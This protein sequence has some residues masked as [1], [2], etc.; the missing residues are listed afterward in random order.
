M[1]ITRR[2]FLKASGAAGAVLIAAPASGLG[3]SHALADV[4][5][6]GG[7]RGY[8]LDTPVFGG[9]LQYFRMPVSDIPARLGLCQEAAFSVIQTYVPWNVHEY[10]AGTLD[11]MGKTHPS[12]PNDHHLDPFDYGDSVGTGGLND[13]DLGLKVNTDLESFLRMCRDYGFSVILR[14][15]PFISDEWRNGG[16]PDWLLQTAPDDM[17]EYGPDGTP[18]L[19][20]PPFSS[21]PAV[22][23]LLGGM[24]LFYFPSP[25]YASPYYLSAVRS[26]LTGFAEFVR[27]WLRSNG[28]PVV[29]VQVDDE[30]CFYYHFGAF[31][32][33][34]N[35][36]MV[37]RYVAA[38]GE[39]PPRAWPL[40]VEGIASLRPAFK[41][42]KFKAQQIGT[43]LGTLAGDLRAAGVDVPITHEM[44]LSLTPPADFAA[45]A[46]AVL[47]QPELYPGA[48]GPEAMPLIELT[49]QAARAAQRNRVN[50]WSA[51]TQ[52]GDLLL[53]SLLLGEGI[54][55]SLQF[56]Y[57]EGVPDGA[58]VASG[59]LGRTLR[60]A[61]RLLTDAKR[62]ADVAIVWDSDLAHAPV[63]SQQ[64]GFAT[65]VFDVIEHHVP[66]LATLL[67]RAGYSFDL[68]DTSA[69][70]AEDYRGYRTI[71]LAS[72]DILP[73]SAQENL[74][75]YVRRGGH[76]VCWPAPPTLDEN[77][78]DCTILARACFDE[79]PDAFYADA[80]QDIRILGRPVTTYMGVQT[81]SL[82]SR[83]KT[84]ASR[85]GA[86]CGYVRR[87]GA[88]KAMLLG[89][90]PAASNL[91]AR[92]GEVLDEQPSPSTATATS[93]LSTA[94]ALAK[95]YFG[96][97]AAAR[98]PAAL[99]NG[100]VETWIVYAYT[101]QR[102]SSTYV[103]TGGALA[104][105]NGDQV[106]GVMQVTTTPDGSTQVLSPPPYCPADAPHVA[107]IQALI[108][109]T[110]QIRVSDLRIQ[111]RVAD[112]A[113][114]SSA[115]VVA[116]N[117]W[118]QNVSVK[119]STTVAGRA[120]Q[121]PR[122]G[123]LT[124]PA[125]T[126]VLLP[127]D[128]PLPNGAKLVQATAQLLDTSA[129]NA[130]STAI[131]LWAPGPA[132]VILSL[133]KKLSSARLDG[134]PTRPATTYGRNVTFDI[135]QGDHELVVSWKPRQPQRHAEQHDGRG[136]RRRARPRHER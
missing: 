82:S 85:Q 127:I 81:F 89:T 53:A 61:G 41:W 95:K 135:A 80:S 16:L 98:L 5:T 75:A 117:R 49:A 48:D 70:Q 119:M 52:E 15:G 4:V 99:T 22:A 86:P 72:A 12:L 36:A 132:E 17:F 9:E 20:S 90:W 1:R 94:A 116:N 37:A 14:P 131:S 79:A 13:Y 66:A 54:I 44:E 10:K 65:D 64:W 97:E 84:I 68:L 126:G 69:A 103:L 3:S 56:N 24:S 2:T 129:P 110:P 29:G 106:V 45:D 38:T 11:F 125:G 21:P 73:R 31:E 128:Y 109:A 113:N 134:K 87:L 30:T 32:V 122:A 26:W 111:A 123:R 35:P 55:G 121:L 120:V 67:L 28:G 92:S 133:P 102:R 130:S 93:Q 47:V 63:N 25:S 27:P 39:Q 118:A 71:L 34:Y 50:V 77:L 40:P 88:G 76:L 105:W 114:G 78:E 58:V 107:A 42:Q 62:R 101:N 115:T 43:F 46:S 83:A 33:D 100:P 18:L 104:Y 91:A 136:Q 51:E 108:G 19:V 124:L 96:A 112:A 57:E 74:V 7:R 6:T 60:T 8:L 23:S 59:L